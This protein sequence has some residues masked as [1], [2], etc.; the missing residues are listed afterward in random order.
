M[1]IGIDV[2][3]QNESGVGRYIRN[4]VKWLKKIDKKNEYT[5]FSPNLRWHSLKEQ[6]LLP[7][8]LEKEN[9]DL[10]HFPYFSVPF[11]YKKPFIVTIHD[12]TIN[13]FSTGKASTLPF[14]IYLLK[15]AGY[16]FILG[17]TIKRAKKIIVPSKT[18]KKEILDH[19]KADPEK[20][21]V[22]YEGVDKKFKV[23][24][25]K[26]KVQTQK[27]KLLRPKQYFLYVGNAY[28]HK[29][30]EKLLRAFLRLKVQ[31]RTRTSSVQ[32]RGSRF[33][34]KTKNL[35]LVLVGKS[36]YFYRRL[37]TTVSKMEIRNEV[38]FY[39]QADDKELSWLYQN[40]IALILPSL[41]EGFGLTALEAMACG[42]LVLASD[43]PALREVCGEA[44][45]YFDPYNVQ[46][47]EGKMEDVLTHDDKEQYQR[48]IREGKERAKMFSWKK[49][50]E[51][52]L[53][54]Y[55]NCF[56]I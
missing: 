40:A 2:R 31:P 42:C 15:H 1:R 45:I 11:F 38:V 8:V 16:R 4:L 28:P 21:A 56:S 48:R 53:K 50:A 10:V 29:N 7:G 9:F 13:H 41:M 24:S 35:K 37:R 18:T 30:L 49:M 52:T 25:S 43:I 23:Q 51:E 27:L 17:Q 3:L 14:P 6:I 33:K 54:V 20:I 46:E 12:L 39:G 26:F 22:I 34:A 44:A 19:F 32:G 36:D 5:L 55:E 47:M